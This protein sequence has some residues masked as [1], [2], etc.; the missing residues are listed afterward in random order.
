[1]GLLGKYNLQ[2]FEGRLGGPAGV[3]LRSMRSVLV[4]GKAKGEGDD[5]TPNPIA[6]KATGP[7]QNSDGTIPGSCTTRKRKSPECKN[8]HVQAKTHICLEVQALGTPEVVISSSAQR[9]QA[10]SERD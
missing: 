2:D 3:G 5:S 7:V 6:Q 9:G 8:K 4:S 1:M 10:E